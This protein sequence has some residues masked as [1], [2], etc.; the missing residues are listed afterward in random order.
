MASNSDPIKAAL[1]A[2][3]SAT[4]TA[5]AAEAISC[6]YIVAFFAVFAAAKLTAA[7]LATVAALD[8]VAAADD[9][10]TA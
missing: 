2:V 9:A 10:I 4:A 6:A 5:F 3:D 1:V 8:A 7:V